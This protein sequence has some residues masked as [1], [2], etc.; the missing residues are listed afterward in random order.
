MYP[1]FCEFLRRTGEALGISFICIICTF[2]PSRLFLKLAE[3]SNTEEI[4][5]M[6]SIIF[7]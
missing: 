7:I 4:I 2:F 5:L 6:G 1:F 3:L